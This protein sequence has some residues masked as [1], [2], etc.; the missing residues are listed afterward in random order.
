MNKLLIALTLMAAFF[1]NQ[2]LAEGITYGK[3][4]DS[5][6]NEYEGEIK[7]DVLHGEGKVTTPDGDLFAGEFKGGELVYGTVTYSSGTLYVGEFVK[8]KGRGYRG[9]FSPHGKGTMTWSSVSSYVGEWKM[10]FRNGQGTMTWQDGDS[11]VGE[12][13]SGYLN[14][15]GTLTWKGVWK[16]EGIF[17]YDVKDGQGKMTWQNGD[18]YVGDFSGDAITGKGTLIWKNGDTYEGEFKDGKMHGQGTLTDEGFFPWSKATIYTGEWKNGNKIKGHTATKK[19]GD[20]GS[21]LGEQI[22]E[23]NCALCHADGMMNSPKIGDKEQWAPRIDQGKEMLV[24]NAINGIRLMPP[25]GGSPSLS[26]EEVA[27]AVVWMA[28]SSGGKLATAD[29]ENKMK[30]QLETT[31]ANKAGK[32]SNDFAAKKIYESCMAANK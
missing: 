22:W 4:T 24:K 9:R 15:Q 1:T 30:L 26:D 2:T 18:S 14:G 29:K 11:Y 16:Y 23:K 5:Y 19:A 32:A 28:N 7:E 17:S 21:I 25:K 31:C 6:G 13:M 10:G 3:Y 20:S 12:W 27:A 8:I